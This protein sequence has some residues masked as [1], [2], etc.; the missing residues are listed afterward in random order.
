MGI[1]VEHQPSA[2]AVGMAAYLAGR[3]KAKQRQQKQALDLHRDNQ[4]MQMQREGMAYRGYLEGQRQNAM[5]TRAEGQR[6]FYAGEAEKNRAFDREQ[7]EGRAQAARR[8]DDLDYAKTQYE[9]AMARL[10]EIRED[11]GGVFAG[12]AQARYDALQQ[13]MNAVDA[14]QDGEGRTDPLEALTAKTKKIQGFVGG[15]DRNRHRVAPEDR[16]GGK[17]DDG[18]WKY[19]REED[20]AVSKVGFVSPDAQQKYYD[21]L[22]RTESGDYLEYDTARGKTNVIAAGGEQGPSAQDQYDTDLGEYEKKHKAL[23]E[24]HLP[25]EPDEGKTWEETVQRVHAMTAG[26]MAGWGDKPPV[27]PPL[28]GGIGG[29]GTAAPSGPP[30]RTIGA[31]GNIEPAPAATTPAP[32]PAVAPAPAPKSAPA[33]APVTATATAPAAQPQPAPAPAAEVQS[34]PTITGSPVAAPEGKAAKGLEDKGY[35]YVPVLDSKGQATGKHAWRRQPAEQT[36]KLRSGGEM[37]GRVY[38][39]GD[40]YRVAVGDGSHITR[41]ITDF[42]TPDPF[43]GGERVTEQ[44]APQAV[45]QAQPQPAQAQPQPA[46]PDGLERLRA[47]ARSGHPGAQKY[48]KEQGES[49]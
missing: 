28:S 30:R 18:T 43:M 36:L 8:S 22:P 12:D 41:D 3:G 27:K 42:E 7:M 9:D 5:N 4:R 16:P 23:T 20:G 37:T 24:K 1:R 38:R 15:Y 19:R 25:E 48:L 35:E 26:M 44:P 47:A 31:S 39:E 21:T 6:E 45:A 46:Q 29:P 34:R 17:W 32:S 10:D 14:D 13:G 2:F 40:K 49:W 33:P 11:T